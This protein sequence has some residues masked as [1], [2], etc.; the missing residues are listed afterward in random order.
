MNGKRY[1]YEEVKNYI[2]SIGLF[3]IS[4]KY[5]HGKEKLI[6]KDNFGYFYTMNFYRIKEGVNLKK[7]HKS[8]P[9][10]IQNIKLWCKLNDKLFELLDNQEYID[11]HSKLN[12]ECLKISCGEVFKANWSDIKSGYGC[13]VCYGRQTTLSNCLSTKN[14]ELAKEWHPNKNGNLTPYDVTEFSNKRVWWLC[15]NGHEWKDK[16]SNRCR[17]IECPYCNHQRAS[18]EYN[19]LICN[20]ELCKEWDYNR[21]KKRPEEYLPNSNKRVY[22]KCDEC[23]YEWKVSIANRNFD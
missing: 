9:Y 2:E 8:N 11:A 17:Y 1:T 10:T 3:L 20:P 12:W 21:N 23:G 18:K 13:G 5:I 14:P 4:D 22:W 19:L 6:I 7:F 16:I 15:G